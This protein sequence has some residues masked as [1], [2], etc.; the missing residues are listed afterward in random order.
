[1]NQKCSYYPDGILKSYR[2]R[3]TVMGT[4]ETEMVSTDCA[5]A[6]YSTKDTGLSDNGKEALADITDTVVKAT[7]VGAA[8]SLIGAGIERMDSDNDGPMP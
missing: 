7:A 8:G 3:S 5:V 6:G 1:M 2:L 4:G